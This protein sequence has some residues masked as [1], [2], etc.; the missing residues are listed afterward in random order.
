MD[1]G[2]FRILYGGGGGGGGSK[3]IVGGIPVGGGGVEGKA[4]KVIQVLEYLN[5][6]GVKDQ[7]GG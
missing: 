4:T 6:G 1:N 5:G 2:A 7:Q 3:T